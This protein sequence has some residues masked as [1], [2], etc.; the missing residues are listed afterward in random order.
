VIGPPFVIGD[1]EIDRIA[2]GTADAIRAVRE[3]G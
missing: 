2:R 3:Q 1:A